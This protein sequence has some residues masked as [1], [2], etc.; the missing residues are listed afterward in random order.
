MTA[1]T[2][3][4]TY[5]FVALLRVSVRARVMGTLPLNG[6]HKRSCST[7]ATDQ[8]PNVFGPNAVISFVFL[9]RGVVYR[10]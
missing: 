3:I 4:Y 6:A 10:S 9:G 5:Y 1:Q 2:E 8:L 7:V